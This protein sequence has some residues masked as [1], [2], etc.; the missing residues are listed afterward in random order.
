MFEKILFP[1][2]GSPESRNAIEAVIE[3]AK[4]HNASLTLVS[5]VETPAE[6]E[7]PSPNNS[8]EAIAKL[9]D[10]AKDLFAQQGLNVQTTERE[11]KPSFAICDVAD[12]I[13][14]DLIVM[15]GSSALVP[16]EGTRESVASRTIGLSPCPVLVIP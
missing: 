13:E 14:A 11:G 9:L 15:G 7:A 4:L 6:G 5:V 1:I 8:A 2:D 12:E 10:S 16:G 3:L